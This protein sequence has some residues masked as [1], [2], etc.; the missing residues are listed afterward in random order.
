MN[1]TNYPNRDALRQALD[2]YLE[3]MSDFIV[4]KLRQNQKQTREE[5]IRQYCGKDTMEWKDIAY[6]LR[7]RDYWTFF[8]EHFKRV[9]EYYEARS[10]VQ[11]IVE[12]R[13]RT[14]HPPWDLKPEFTKTQLFMIAEILSKIERPTQQREVKAI[15]ENLFYDNTKDLLSEVEE[16]IK[17]LESEK[18]EYEK[19]NVELSE[20]LAEKNKILQDAFSE[21]E[22]YEKNNAELSQQII[23]N[24]LRIEKLKEA[25]AK[26]KQYKED[27]TQ[28]REKL[29]QTKTLLDDYKELL[30]SFEKEIK[31]KKAELN[32]VKKK[33]SDTSNQLTVEQAKRN[34]YKENLISLEKQL[35]EIQSIKQST[36][37]HLTAMQS[38]FDMAIIDSQMVIPIF[39]QLN[40]FSPIRIFDHRETDKK[41]YLLN[42][43]KLKKPTLIYVQ[44][45]ERLSKFFTDI[46]NEK[47]ELIG[48]HCASMSKTEERE[49][50]KKLKKGELFAIISNDVF[51]TLT[52]NISVEHIVFCH[53]VPGLEMIYEQCKLAS[54]SYQ[55]TFM[56]LIF[57]SKEDRKWIERLYPDRKSLEKVYRGLND[58]VNMNGNFVNGKNIIKKL[59]V[60]DREFN[61]G[62]AILEELGLLERNEIGIRSLPSSGKKLEDSKIYIEGE[63]L[64]KGIKEFDEF[65]RD[66]TAEQIWKKLVE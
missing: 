36:E 40:K 21:K 30:E 46:V 1:S 62:C 54:A 24:A 17:K 32:V 55:N 43:L 15:Q 61:A 18:Q 58:K 4:K 29:E 60:H 16:R 20:S 26:N 5:I 6:I 44:D 11:L 48:R 47:E 31:D 35:V 39:P 52:A 25:E 3:A 66:L 23:D 14:S 28:T 56:H 42:L 9:D 22:E 34:E 7:N 64:K 45:E 41:K 33:L 10:V 53:L 51:S 65:Q 8:E 2:I 57:D 59:D 37:V 19:R 38:V 49:L 27:L 50:L 63:K 12:G 13:N